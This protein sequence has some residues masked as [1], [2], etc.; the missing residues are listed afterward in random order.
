MQKINI[1][2]LQG[3]LG[4]FFSQLANE[5][6]SSGYITHKINFNGGDR[7]YAGADHITD[8]SGLPDDW[9]D[10]LEEYLE[11]H[12]IAS[13]FLLGDCRFYHREARPVCNKLNV[14]FMVFEE[15]YLRPNTIT[16]E[17]YGVNALSQLDL[18]EE[19][20]SNTEVVSTTSP[21]TIGGTMWWRTVFAAFYYWAALFQRKRFPHYTHHRAFNP[22]REGF[23]WQRGFLRKKLVRLKDSKL[24]KHLMTN[25]SGRFVLVP[26]QVHDDSQKIYHSDYHSVEAFITEVMGS[27]KEHA[28]TSQQ[29]CFK[30]HPMDIGYTHYGRL[31][32]KVASGMGISNRV[33][34]CH[35]IPLPDLYHHAS[36]VLTVN[37][38]VGL[39]A[40]LHKLPTKTMGKAMYDMPGLTHQGS[41]ASFWQ[42]PEA[43]DLERFKK[44]QSYIFQKTQVNGSFFKLFDLGCTNSVAF[45][46]KNTGVRTVASLTPVAIVSAQADSE[47]ITDSESSLEAA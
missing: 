19:T 40:I 28:E 1:L 42:Q 15:G 7:Y 20:I 18:S 9:S 47:E 14:K 33:F 5:F 4:P 25:C 34:Y 6:S 16:L 41:L 21:V 32:K 45:F 8:Y 22:L 36:A 10:F 17:Q 2:F 38:T 44:F 27:F 13:V 30:H 43:V 46:E 11:L 26:L 35:N 24:R 3:P 31:I 37:S 29:L 39:S 12:N 23:C